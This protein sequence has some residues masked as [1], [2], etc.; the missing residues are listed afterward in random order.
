MLRNVNVNQI[1]SRRLL[2]QLICTAALLTSISS[3]CLAARSD[4]FHID[5]NTGKLLDAN[6]IVFIM[7]GVNHMVADYDNYWRNWYCNDNGIPDACSPTGYFA[8]DS[9]SFIGQKGFNTIRIQW[10]MT[11]HGGS[12]S[13][14]RLTTAIDQTI[15]NNML[16][17]IHIHD[18]TD[19][20]DAVCLQNAATDWRNFWRGLDES[21]RELYKRHLIINIANEWGRW[22]MDL[23]N[24]GDHDSV[25]R[26]LWASEYKTAID[27]I[28]SSGYEGV[29]IIDGHGAGQRPEAIVEQG[30]ELL[31]YDPM[32][33]I[34]FGLHV[35]ED[36]QEYYDLSAELNILTTNVIP[37]HIGE[38][39][40]RE[41]TDVVRILRCAVTYDIGYIGWVWQGDSTSPYGSC[42]NVLNIVEMI[43]D[44][45]GTG[46]N[47]TNECFI[48]FRDWKGLELTSWG[49]TLIPFEICGG[50]D[51]ILNS[52]ITAFDNIVCSASN[53]IRMVSGFFVEEHVRFQARIVE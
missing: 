5:L 15:Q 52:G 35:Y 16:P 10:R 39:G 42:N 38:F 26:A 41:G 44:I 22:N 13:T 20:D 31:D 47:E 7:F 29:L 37:I 34:M 32:N 45:P 6:G 43:D 27:T 12:L 40:P 17:I 18:C 14:E 23:D 46:S 30:Q 25:D 3:L 49:T 9:I 53:S 24:D 48:D 36:F 19:S 11:P 33:N 51:E 21:K 2:G 1:S 8:A 4:G 28:R 50:V